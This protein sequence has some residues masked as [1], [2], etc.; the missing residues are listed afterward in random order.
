[1]PAA[2]TTP[3]NGWTLSARGWVGST[4]PDPPPPPHKS[5]HPVAAS[6]TVSCSS[7]EYP[8]DAARPP[9]PTPPHDCD[10][11]P[12]APPVPVDQRRRS[13][14]RPAPSPHRAPFSV[15]T[16]PATRTCNP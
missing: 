5:P 1:A 7:Q 13:T 4:P 11:P 2:G 3:Y 15:P 6:P 9:L 12:S 14:R 8:W 16:R 10:I